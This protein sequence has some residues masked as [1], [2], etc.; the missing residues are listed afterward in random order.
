MNR[1]EALQPAP[2]YLALLRGIVQDVWHEEQQ[3]AAK[4]RVQLESE[5]AT[6]EQLLDQLEKAF[7]WEKRID[8]ATYDR[9]TAKLREQSVLLDLEKHEAR[10]EELDVD[11]V[12]AFAEHVASNAARLW[13]EASAD[14]KGRLQRVFFPD[15]LNFDGTQF[16]TAVTCLAFSHLPEAKVVE[17]NV[18]SPTGTVKRWQ[19]PISGFSDLQAA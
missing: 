11:G 18:A 1:L 4:R 12:L 13:C 14:Q 10:L 6:V 9:Q 3:E 19:L 5:I 8:K 17:N 15:G 2:G 16:G 7:I